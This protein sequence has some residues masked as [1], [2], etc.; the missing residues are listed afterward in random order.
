MED[1]KKEETK[2][3][4]LNKGP[5]SS[6]GE[7]EV[8]YNDKEVDTYPEEET[9]E[10]CSNGYKPIKKVNFSPPMIKEHNPNEESAKVR[11]KRRA[12]AIKEKEEIYH[13]DKSMYPDHPTPWK[14]KSSDFFLLHEPRRGDKKVLNNSQKEFI[15]VYYA[16]SVV[17][18]VSL[19]QFLYT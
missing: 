13:I 1:A 17:D 7:N 2:D 19:M 11:A 6:I 18:E 12:V 15:L 14:G 3:E 5:G 9:K 16:D 10:V 4:Q 8:T